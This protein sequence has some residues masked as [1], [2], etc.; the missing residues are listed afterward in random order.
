VVELK[1]GVISQY[2][3]NPQQFGFSKRSETELNELVAS[4]TKS[5]LA[6]IKQSMT[7]DTSAAA[8]IVSLNAGAAIYASGVATNLANGIAMAQDA[9]STGLA[10][11]RFNELVRVTKMMHEA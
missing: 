11:E 2:E 6:L 5:S 7:D 4:S 3:I 9:I 1:D 10:N 8:D